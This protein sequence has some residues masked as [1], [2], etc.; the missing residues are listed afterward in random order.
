MGPAGTTD[1]NGASPGDLVAWARKGDQSAWAALTAR[2]S[3]MVW[4][5]ARA[6]G[7]GEADA[8]DVTQTTW[9][10]LVERIDRIRDPERV[11]AWLAVTARRETVRL[12]RH[13]VGGRA[14]P[15]LAATDPGPDHVCL[16]RERL[17]VVMTAIQALPELCRH[18]LRLFALSPGYAEVAAAL[19]MPIGSVGPTRTR[20]LTSLRARLGGV[21]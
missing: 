20:C 17:R 5:I 16:D 2:Y 13:Q 3:G 18:V 11:G 8:A 10:R 15:P 14:L 19:D 9:L 4:A 1:T 12:R 21:L 6:H 7:L